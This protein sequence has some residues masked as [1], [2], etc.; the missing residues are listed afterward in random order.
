MSNEEVGAYFR[1]LCHQADKGHLSEETLLSICGETWK[2]VSRKFKRDTNGLYYN[3]RLEL[4]LSKAAEFSKSR[5]NNKLIG[6]H[7]KNMCESHDEHMDNDNDSDNDNDR[8]ALFRDLVKLWFDLHQEYTGVKP[9]WIQT[10]KDNYPRAF[11][12]LSFL[13]RPIEEYEKAMRCGFTDIYHKRVIS[14]AY[15]ATKFNQLLTIP[16]RLSPDISQSSKSDNQQYQTYR[17]IR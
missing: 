15:I 3:Q 7:M 14:P 11:E 17:P 16:P 13:K 5:K 12:A 9:A 1:G 4:E 6:Q 2:T 10:G 8:K